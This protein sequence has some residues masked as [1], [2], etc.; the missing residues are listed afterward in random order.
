MIRVARARLMATTIA[1][2][3]ASLGNAQTW[4]PIGPPGGD[5]RSLTID[6]NDPDVVYL[7]TIDGA[8]YRSKNGGRSWRRLDPGFPLRAHSLDDIIVTV[9]G[10]IFIG[11]WQVD[12][13]GGGVAR[14]LDGG[15]TFELLD[16]IKGHSVRGLDVFASNPNVLVAA[17]IDGVF[18]SENG[19]ASWSRISPEGHP[20]LRNVG[21][22]AVDRNDPNVIY[23]GTWHLPWK[24]ID[25]GRNWRRISA[26]MIPD[27]DV[28][29][30]TIDLHS[31]RTIYATACSGV[32]RS[33]SRGDAWSKARGIPNSSRRT[34][35]FIQDPRQ[36][37]TLF[38]GTTEGLY[39]SEDGMRSWRRLTSDRLV[40]NTIAI[41][42]SGAFLLG[43]D[44][45][46]VLR[47]DDRGRTWTSA[48]QGFLER[49]VARI[50]IDAS[51]TRLFAGLVNAHRH[52]GVRVT[53]PDNCAW[54]VLGRG[55]EGREVLALAR[56]SHGTFVGTDDGIHVHRPP[57]NVWRR[58]STEDGGLERHP[59]ITEIL[60]LSDRVLL[61]A[62]PSGLWRSEDAGH[63]WTR[64]MLG[65]S[66]V[67]SAIGRST[68][69]PRMV[70]AATPLDLFRSEDGGGSWDL[71]AGAPPSGR[72]QALG[73]L[74]TD[75][76]VVFA[77]TTRGLF[78]S[79]DGGRSWR[80][81]GGGLPH[82]SIPD[83]AVHPDGRTVYA[84]NYTHG[85]VYRSGDAGETWSRMPESGL[86]SERIWALELDPTL[87][88]FLLAAAPHGGIHLLPLETS[89]SGEDTAPAVESRPIPSPKCLITEIIRRL[90]RSR[91]AD[92]APQSR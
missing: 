61:A 64:R 71:V 89:V 57:S 58:M 32:Y 53:A 19:G 82:G 74:P 52:G 51:E 18:R 33:T 41:L 20:G 47:S 84:A 14:S 43:C 29:T 73:F 42:Q 66:S 10:E 46:G 34:R 40:I 28:M 9:R 2:S 26:G 86:H 39:V 76:G 3:V 16:G 38:A 63:G 45:V 8:I 27:S 85:G 92:L 59:R 48:N 70:L 35:A 56:T 79:R 13:G 24:T 81:R 15:R 5:V 49:S 83:I 54:C 80:H 87:S 88:A 17:A 90:D 31:P 44:G 1:V 60:A 67:V 30:I 12:G 23:A 77:G 62:S 11:Y 69:N 6:R 91:R 65:R 55:I 78:K 75:D 72:T 21:S 68:V 7:G 4:T 37:D 50:A 22:I 25:G 36:P